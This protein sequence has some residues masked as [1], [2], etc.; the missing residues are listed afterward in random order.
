[1][2]SSAQLTKPPNLI[3]SYLLICHYCLLLFTLQF[4][5]FSI[6]DTPV[7]TVSVRPLLGGDSQLESFLYGK[8]VG[9]KG[10]KEF[11]HAYVI[12]AIL[13][14]HLSECHSALVRLF[15]PQK[16][17]LY[18]IFH[19]ILLLKEILG[20]TAGF[21]ESVEADSTHARDCPVS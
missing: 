10:I 2:S 21:I 13:F 19:A 20:I 12:L 9:G 18:P 17:L 3:K 1:V 6:V 15:T 5:R 7:E 11:S 14:L 8:A 4:F 16:H